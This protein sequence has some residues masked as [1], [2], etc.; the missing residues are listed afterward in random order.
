[1]STEDTRNSSTYLNQLVL[2]RDRIAGFAGNL[3][4]PTARNLII[5]SK[6]KTGNS[7]ATSYLEIDPIPIIDR[8]S[9]RIASA[10]NG[11]NSITIKLDDL[12]IKGISRSYSREQ[13]LGTSISYFVDSEVVNNS[14]SGGFECDLISVDEL[15]LTWNL[16][17]RR[18]T[19]DR[20]NV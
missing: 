5:R 18:K 3:N 7:I 14:I 6:T 17:L 20:R 12:Q 1:M 11:S 15:P 2:M 19:D 10:F 8:V 16:I 13:I 4:I 9:P